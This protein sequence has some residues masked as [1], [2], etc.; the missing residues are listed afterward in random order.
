M[1]HA[2]ICRFAE[3]INGKRVTTYAVNNHYHSAMVFLLLLVTVLEYACITHTSVR[4]DRGKNNN[5]V[6]ARIVCDAS[7][8]RTLADRRACTFA[9]FTGKIGFDRLRLRT[10]RDGIA[11]DRILQN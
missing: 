11:L 6:G 3:R 5:R 2:A 1:A 8:L 7:T 9:K 4:V 10:R